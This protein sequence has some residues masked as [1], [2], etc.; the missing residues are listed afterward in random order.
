MIVL[1]AD[2]RVLIENT[3]FSYLVNNYATGVGTFALVNTD[4]FAADD[5]IIVEEIGKEN[6]EIFRIGA[7]NN[8]TGEITLE[9]KTGAATTTKH[10]HSESTK[11]HWCPYNEIQFYWTAAAGDITDETPPFDTDNALGASMDIDPS[12]WYTIYEDEVNSTGF[13]WFKY[14]NTVTSQLSTYSNPIPYQGFDRNTVAEVFAD[15]DSLMNTRELSLVSQDEKFRWL[16]E[17]LALLQNKLNLNNTEYFVSTSQTLNL[18][19]GTQEYL[20]PEDFSDLVT[21]TDTDGFYSN[22]SVGFLSINKID[23]Y[24]GTDQRYYLRGRYLGF[25]PAPAVDSTLQYTY[26]KKSMR[27][28]GMSDYIDLPDNAFY[29]LKDF[30]LYRAYMKFMNPIA[31]QYQEAFVGSVNLFIETAVK[32][33][34][35]LDSWEPHPTT[36]V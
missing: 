2:N 12:S 5:F 15:F 33:D 29:A 26:R 32:R 16:N 23:G 22:R 19:A 35:N 9:D 17:A 30:M 24:N 21:I 13:G 3:E 34:A 10:A 20:L 7:V 27:V 8:L 4:G 25:K 14:E 36:V 1:Q 18:V 11:V 31:K 28:D 6:A